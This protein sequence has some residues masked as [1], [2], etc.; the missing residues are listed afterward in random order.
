[1][2]EGFARE[3]IDCG[4]AEIHLV[5]GGT[6]PPLLLLHGFMSCGLQ[7]QPNRKALGERFR[8][9]WKAGSSGFCELKYLIHPY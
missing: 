9:D 1:M 5:H 6:G 8:L 2:F 4:E 7:W 3:W